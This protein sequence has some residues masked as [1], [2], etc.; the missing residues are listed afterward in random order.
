MT[1]SRQLDILSPR[2]HADPFPTLHRMRAEAP[3]VRMKLPIVGRTWLAI[4][5]DAC[6]TLLKDHETFVRTRPTQGSGRRPES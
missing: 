6:A 1:E 2:F 4:T 3:V 5:H